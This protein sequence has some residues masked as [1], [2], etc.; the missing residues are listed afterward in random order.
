MYVEFFGLIIQLMNFKP[1][2]TP[3]SMEAFMYYAGVVI[4]SDK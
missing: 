3:P 1:D 4:V 2:E